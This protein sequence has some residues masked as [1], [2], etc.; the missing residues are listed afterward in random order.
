M[1]IRPGNH[2]FVN[3]PLTEKEKQKKNSILNCNAGILLQAT[4]LCF[5]VHFE[6]LLLQF[7]FLTKYSVYSGHS[8]HSMKIKR[9]ILLIYTSIPEFYYLH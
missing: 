6:V 9:K 2:L 7:L 8:D 3:S 4:Y 5:K 1:E